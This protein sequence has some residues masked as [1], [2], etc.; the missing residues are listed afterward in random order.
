MG[1]QQQQQQQHNSVDN[2][3]DDDGSA[4]DVDA[5]NDMW[6][7]LGWDPWSEWNRDSASAHKYIYE[8]RGREQDRYFIIVWV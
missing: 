7:W 8:K 4:D 2:D 5:H 3:G 1:Q 6:M